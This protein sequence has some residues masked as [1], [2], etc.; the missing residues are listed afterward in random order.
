MNFQLA[1]DL[2]VLLETAA[3]LWASRRTWISNTASHVMLITS[4][5]AV[6]FDIFF[7]LNLLPPC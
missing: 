7:L 5:S 3:N 2:V 4:G 1:R 6:S